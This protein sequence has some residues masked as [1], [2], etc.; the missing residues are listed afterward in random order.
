MYDCLNFDCLVFLEPKTPSGE[1][2]YEELLQL[3]VAIVDAELFEA[4]RIK[5]LKAIDVKYSNDRVESRLGLATS[6]EYSTIYT[7]YDPGEKTIIDGLGQRIFAILCLCGIMILLH[8]IATSGN[9]A[10]GQ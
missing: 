1:L 9:C 6:E 5:D 4:I 8:H 2:T 3:L 10:F 7:G